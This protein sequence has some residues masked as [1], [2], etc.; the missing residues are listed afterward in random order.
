MASIDREKVPPFM[1]RMF[2]RQGGFHPLQSFLPDRL[3]LDESLQ[4][5]TWK[6][7]TLRE[8]HELLV[9]GLPAA[10]TARCSFRIVYMDKYRAGEFV[11]KDIG[12]YTPEGHPD[13]RPGAHTTSKSLEDARFVIGDFIDVKVWTDRGPRQGGGRRFRDEGRTW[14]DPGSDDRWG[15]D[16]WSRDGRDGRD[17]RNGRDWDRDR[18]QDRGDRWRDNR[19]D[20]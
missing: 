17:A 16:R 1:L 2:F 7:C 3:P 15:R 13:F 19:R 4:I 5:Y 10:V 18:D 11:C 12:D 6:D 14:R 8:L 9:T 20:Y